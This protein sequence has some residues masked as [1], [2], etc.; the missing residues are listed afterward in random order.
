MEENF[1]KIVVGVEESPIINEHLELDEA[2][3]E[4]IAM[5]L[6][7]L[8]NSG[9]NIIMVSAGSTATGIKITG[10]YPQTLAE[11][12]AISAIGQVELIKKYQY[13]FD[14]YDHVVAQ[15]LIARD[16]MQ[17]QQRK[18]N[19]CNT[20]DKL[21]DLDIIPIINENDTVSTADIELENNYPL[22]AIVANMTK[23]DLVILIKKNVRG[24]YFV[25]IGHDYVKVEDEEELFARIN[26]FKE[27]QQIKK[28]TKEYPLTIDELKDLL[29]QKELKTPVIKKE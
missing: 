14:V 17:N 22:T 12:Q 20:F 18:Q 2:K 3:I 25:V 6:S 13:S 29:D 19:A 27:S 11:H 9:A 1:I 15:V 26:Q 8:H 21:L 5:I 10:K 16:I 4:R 7:D 28:I 23:A 24:P